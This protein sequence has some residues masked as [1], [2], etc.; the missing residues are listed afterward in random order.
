VIHRTAPA[1]F[2]ALAA[3]A[4]AHAGERP[5]AQIEQQLRS[6]L[7]S[8]PYRI[9]DAARAG[10]IRYRLQLRDGE[11]NWP[12]TAEQHVERH[13]DTTQL[14]IC[15]DCGREASPDPA[16]LKRY[17]EP[18]A[19]VQSR[20][21]RV[22][23]FARTAK[24][25][26]V[27]ARMHSLVLAVQKHMTGA[28]DFASYQSATQ[29][30]DSRGGDCTEFAI[31]LAAAARARGIPARVVA[32]L[33]YAN[34]FLERSHAFVPH[35]WVQAWDGTRWV[36]YDAALGHFDA[37]H[38]ALAIGD[39]SPDSL[40]GTMATIARLRIVDAASVAAAMQ[41]RRSRDRRRHTAERGG[42]ACGA[43]T[44]GQPSPRARPAAPAHR[45][46]R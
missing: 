10:K 26:S 18:N 20:D 45:P 30:L 12:E 29:A 3:T 15:G 7:V 16:Q 28:I 31:L 33:S 14:T 11:W 25:R 22:V 17:R 4:F 6:L 27:D 42:R 8:S 9:P 37:T 44:C 43:P 19:W 39:G 36:S 24:G 21:R 23:A 32:G 1:F 2:A 13:G 5:D 35:M 38:I 34:R 41:E 40:S 46:R